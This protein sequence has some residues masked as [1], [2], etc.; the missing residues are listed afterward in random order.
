M[1]PHADLPTHPRPSWRI[2]VRCRGRLWQRPV[3]I[4][5]VQNPAAPLPTDR[6]VHFHH[7]DLF[8]ARIRPSQA[9]EAPARRQPVMAKSMAYF[10]AVSGSAGAHAAQPS[11]SSASGGA[12][13]GLPPDKSV[14]PS[15]DS[16]APLPAG[17]VHRSAGTH[18]GAWSRQSP[19]SVCAAQNRQGTDSDT[20][21]CSDRASRADT[22]AVDSAQ[23]VRLE[24]GP[25]PSLPW[26]LP[27]LPVF[28]G[29]RLERLNV[30]RLLGDYLLHRRFSSSSWRSFFTSL[31]SKP[32]YFARHL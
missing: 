6:D 7:R 8:G 31:T 11:P 18:S 23:S 2:P 12:M 5:P 17:A 28:R 30:Q 9:C 29:D 21:T 16:P 13:T 20:G 32:E 3:G 25:P 26:A 1:S 24:P 15:R 10:L 22:R 14:R 4:H 19:E 27:V